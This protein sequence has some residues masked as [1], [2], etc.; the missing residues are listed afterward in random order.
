MAPKVFV[1]YRRDDARYPAERIYD[2]L[3]RVLGPDSV[4]MD[5]DSIPDGA[6]FRKIL[7]D[8]VGRCDILLAL[9]GHHWIDAKDSAT[10]HRRLDNPSD[11]VRIEIAE[12]LA[13]DIRVVPVLL[14]DMPMPRA[15]QLPDDLK[16]LA[17]RQARPIQQRTFDHDVA[18]LIRRLG[19]IGLPSPSPPP[20]ASADDERYRAEGRIKVDCPSELVQGA[21]EG[22]FL[23]G[24]GRAE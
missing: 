22:W 21:P 24:A 3:R 4:F 6:N 20:L 12:A 5:V 23:P 1:S 14:D 15:S 16:E 13:R 2:A 18:E 17:D 9:I 10:G 7:K 8:W 19:L 11:F